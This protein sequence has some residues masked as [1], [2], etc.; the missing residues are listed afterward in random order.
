MHT[1]TQ[2]KL[3]SKVKSE[4]FWK[5]RWQ[6]QWQQ[7]V[8]KFSTFLFARLPEHISTAHMCDLWKGN[9][10]IPCASRWFAYMQSIIYDY[11]IRELV[12]Y[13]WWSRY[14]RCTKLVI[15]NIEQI[16]LIHRLCVCIQ[17]NICPYWLIETFGKHCDIQ[18]NK[19]FKLKVVWIMNDTGF[20]CFFYNPMWYMCQNKQS[21]I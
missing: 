18:P 16:C 6:W 15:S 2:M 13:A 12:V 4:Y 7:I 20:P 3:T 11:F 21:L 8:F 5:S 1:V 19:N 14:L 17:L 10:H 9:T